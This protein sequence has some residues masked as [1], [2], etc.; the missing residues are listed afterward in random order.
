MTLKELP[1]WLHTV[2]CIGG[3]AL[4]VALH[5]KWHPLRRHLSDGFDFLRTHRLPLWIIGA[6]ILAHELVAPDEYSGANGL[7]HGDYNDLLQDFTMLGK[8]AAS[9]V[10]ILFHH[11]FPPWP[12][13]LLLPV[14][15]VLL[16]VELMRFP[17]R[18]QAGRVRAEQGMALIL[19]CVASIA[20]AGVGLFR[21]GN[22]WQGPG[23]VVW[24]TVHAFFV[25]LAAGAFQVWLARFLIRW[26]I[27][28]SGDDEAE[29]TRTAMQECLAR[30]RNILWLGAFNAVWLG[31]WSWQE[32]VNAWVPWILLI[33]MLFVFGA[34]PLAVAVGTGSFLEA[35]SQAMRAIWRSCIP[36]AGFVATA[37]VLFGL[38]EYSVAAIGSLAVAPTW[39]QPARIVATVLTL[40][41]L[42]S[43]LLPSA[44]LLLYRT[45]F[46]GTNPAEP[47]TS[48]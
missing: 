14:W 37:V 40:S 48:P 9:R 1:L 5:L 26:A 43:W 34:L 4:G 2:L 22:P 44:M 35:G 45:G 8:H 42:Q 13:S 16:A 12:L 19:L 15:T 20:W 17:Y 24:H 25:S 3:L 10:I 30:W 27:P 6:G 18:Y 33:E 23:E 28:A 39:T 36:L 21:F 29:D 32:T 46:Q 38:A 47:H 7:I 11:A 31:L 41:V